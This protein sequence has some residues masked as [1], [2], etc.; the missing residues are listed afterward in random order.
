MIGTFFAFTAAQANWAAFF[1]NF[2][3][4]DG[5]ATFWASWAL[6][7]RSTGQNLAATV[8]SRLDDLLTFTA[9]WSFRSVTS[10][11]NTLKI[12]WTTAFF[13]SDNVSDLFAF[14]FTAGWLFNGWTF[15]SLVF[16][17]TSKAWKTL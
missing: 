16:N 7:D 5:V 10:P 12:T 3:T 4:R 8:I 6:H 15:K 11:W 14:T 17:R 9:E 1:I 2:S 13:T